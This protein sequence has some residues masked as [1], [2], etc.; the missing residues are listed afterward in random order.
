MHKQLS[1]ELQL[2]SNAGETFA[3][4]L[5]A[6]FYDDDSWR[7]YFQ[8]APVFGPDPGN[9]F[10]STS[11]ESTRAVFGQANWQLAQRWSITGGYRLNRERHESSTIGTGVDDSPTLA[12]SGLDWSND[13]WR[14]DAAF[15]VNDVIMIYAGAATGFKSGGLIF[16]SGGVA[17]E[18]DPEH[19]TAY[20]T[21]I[22]TQ[23]LDRRLTFNAAAYYY[24]FRDLQISTYTNT[25]TGP[26]FE[27][28]N[29]AKVEISGIDS[30]ASYR[31]SDRLHISGGVVWLPRREFVKYRNDV[32]GDTL[33]GNEVTRAPEWTVVFA[34][35]HDYVF[36]SGGHLSTRLEYNYRSDF[37][38][39]T[40]NNSMFSQE[41]FS[42]LNLF[43]NFEPESKNWYV[44]ASGRNLRNADY[45]NQVFLQAS[46]GYP[47][48]YE[49]GLGYRF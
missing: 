39:T 29:A 11:S 48:T 18:Y 13:S 36:R 37:F 40:D 24:D 43:L 49:A 31:I 12:K 35:D 6:Y 44:F 28:D 22:K 20:E 8:H 23:W 7:N 42:L 30:D 9:D 15:A 34:I 1:E 32:D 10:H 16:R 47:A 41:A 45:Y 21:G 26:V 3:W 25:G 17:D 33:S 19:L 46:P 14:I 4:L 27:T 2:A 5:G 38:Y